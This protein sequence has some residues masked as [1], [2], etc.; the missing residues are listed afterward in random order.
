[1]I[2]FAKDW[3]KFILPRKRDYFMSI[4]KNAVH[5]F[6]EMPIQTIT[7]TINAKRIKKQVFISI[8][9]SGKSKKTSPF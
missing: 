6:V 3:T 8:Q 1:M 9:L 4:H 7:G 2:Q 5:L